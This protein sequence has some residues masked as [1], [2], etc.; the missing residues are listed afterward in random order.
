L[1]DL[2][3]GQALCD[4]LKQYQLGV[5]TSERVVEDVQVSPEFFAQI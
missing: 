5:V 4:L 1:I 3:D 2:I